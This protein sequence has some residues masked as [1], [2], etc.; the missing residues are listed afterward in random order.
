MKRWQW[1]VVI[2]TG[3]LIVS[4]LGG[5][6][7]YAIGPCGRVTVGDTYGQVKSIVQSWNSAESS[8]FFNEAIASSLTTWRNGLNDI[9]APA[10]L[11]PAKSDLLNGMDTVIRA[12]QDAA[13]HPNVAEVYLDFR[14]GGY[15]QMKRGGAELERINGCA[16]FCQ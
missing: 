3:L 8:G 13:E 11:Q 7:W 2:V 1:V 10:C 5:G 12:Y 15:T 9:T 4:V 16:P 6:A 14:S